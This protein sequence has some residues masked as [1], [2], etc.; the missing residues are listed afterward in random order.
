MNKDDAN[1]NISQKDKSLTEEDK[2]GLK[3]FIEILRKQKTREQE[4]WD[5]LDYIRNNP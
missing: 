4:I 1:Q 3:K 2:A 5:F